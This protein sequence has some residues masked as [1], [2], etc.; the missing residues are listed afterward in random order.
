[1]KKALVK[2]KKT[3]VSKTQKTTGKLKQV[4]RPGST[5]KTQKIIRPEDSDEGK[6]RFRSADSKNNNKSIENTDKGETYL[7]GPEDYLHL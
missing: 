5:K 2:S 4:A 3:K 1:M 7:I 6:V